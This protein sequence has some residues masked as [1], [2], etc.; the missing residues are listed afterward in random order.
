MTKLIIDLTDVLDEY[1]DDDAVVVWAPHHREGS[2]GQVVNT[3]PKKISLTQGKADQEIE[4]GPMKIK[5]Q[6]IGLSDTQEKDVVVPDQDSVTLRQLLEQGFTYTPPVVTAVQQARN[7][8]MEYMERAEAGA[9]RV[10][11]AEQVGEWAASASADAGRA[12]DEADRAAENADSVDPENILQSAAQHA[13]DGD[14]ETLRSAQDYTD[15]VVGAR[16][17][18]VLVYT[19]TGS[20]TVDDFP[21]ARI[22][23]IVERKSDGYRWEVTP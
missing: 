6:C 21:D 20:P 5:I 4:P 10:G 11:T 1:H 22:G 23:D 18:R 13:D 2:R 9:G 12:K 16:S 17:A 7:Q 3:R 15:T 8:T 19:G 14:D